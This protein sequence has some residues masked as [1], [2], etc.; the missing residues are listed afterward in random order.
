LRLPHQLPARGSA[1]SEL[2]R[3]ILRMTLRR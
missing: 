3:A 2:D 1:R